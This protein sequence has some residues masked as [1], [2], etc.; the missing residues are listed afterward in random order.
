MKGFMHSLSLLAIG[1]A[2]LMA[3]AATVEAQQTEE[4]MAFHRRQRSQR[5]SYQAPGTP[6]AT[7][8]APMPAAAAPGGPAAKAPAVAPVPA[9]A[10]PPETPAAENAMP[11]GTGEQYASAAPSFSPNMIGDLMAG[12]GFISFS[13]YSASVPIAGGDRLFKIAENN[14]PIPTNRF[15]YNYNHFQNAVWGWNQRDWD[16]RSQRLRLREDVPPRLGLLR[17][18]PAHR[19]RLG[20]RP[21]RLLSRHDFGNG[22]RR[23]SAG[24]QGAVVARAAARRV[25]GR[26]PHS[27]HGQGWPNVPA[28]ARG[29]RGAGAPCGEPVAPRS[30]VRR[31][32]VGGKPLLLQVVLRRQRRCERQRRLRA[33]LPNRR[34]RE[35]RHLPGSDPGL[36]RLQVGLL[37]LPK[38]VRLLADRRHTHRGVALHDGASRKPTS[39]GTSSE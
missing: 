1:L 31:L 30:A 34:T 2:G 5:Y 26:G 38:S 3:A 7:D 15:F 11:P 6:G 17:D 29:R 20:L 25:D 9:P 36:L 19:Q 32:G 4:E 28:D 24:V 10:L 22:V 18:P 8:A 35:A 23:H 37:A 39:S 33:G 12:S 16:V 21:A 13:S 14:N 27:P